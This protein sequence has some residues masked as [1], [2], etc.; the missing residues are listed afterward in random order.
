MNEVEVGENTEIDFITIDGSRVWCKLSEAP[1]PVFQ[2]WDFG[3]SD[4]IHLVNVPPSKLH[5]NGTVIWDINLSRIQNVISGK[6]VFQLAKGSKKPQDVQWN[7]QY[8]VA[9]FESKELL[10]LDFSNVFV[11]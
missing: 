7:G 10:I 3:I 4:S 11:Q 1:E 8:L 5:P 2:G 6:T 9:C